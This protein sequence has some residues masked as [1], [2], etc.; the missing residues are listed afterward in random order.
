MSMAIGHFAFGA[1]T[2][3]AGYQLSRPEIRRKGPSKWLVAIVGGLWAMFPD[4]AKFVD[5]LEGFHD[6]LWANV[7][8]F[9]QILDRIDTYDSILGGAILVGYMG[10]FI[11]SLL[12]SDVW[13][14]LRH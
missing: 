2:V 3:L 9:H 12:I 7:C 1:G 6:S 4:L 11:V 14:H 8:F 5:G 13:H 10:V